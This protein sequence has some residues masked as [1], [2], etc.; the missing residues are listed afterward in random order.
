MRGIGIDLNLEVLA[1]AKRN[2]ARLRRLGRL[3]GST[4]ELHHGDWSQSVGFSYGGAALIIVIPPW[5]DAYTEHGLDLRRTIPP[6]LHLLDGI[7]ASGGIGPLF[8]LIQT[9]P[10]SIVESVEEILRKYPKFETLTS[11][12]PQVAARTDYVLIQLR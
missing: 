7:R 6:V 5:G 12:D 4:I 8:S 2:F 1:N 11:D 10:Q 9:M 3:R